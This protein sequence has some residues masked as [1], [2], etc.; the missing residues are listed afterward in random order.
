MDK[1]LLKRVV[2]CTR[3]PS[4]GRAI[5]VVNTTIS[6]NVRSRLNLTKE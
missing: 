4:V 1:D 3:L 5:K 6:D 2:E